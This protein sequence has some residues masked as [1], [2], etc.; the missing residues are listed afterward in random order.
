M[1]GEQLHVCVV[2]AF[3]RINLKVC[4]LTVAAVASSCAQKEPVSNRACACVCVL[5]HVFFMSLIIVAA[6]SSLIRLRP[7]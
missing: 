4:T 1:Q 7:F 5:C 2:N 3:S 6:S